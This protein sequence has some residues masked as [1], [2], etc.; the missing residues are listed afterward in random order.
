MVALPRRRIAT[1]NPQLDGRDPRLAWL[2]MN[3]GTI[4][5]RKSAPVAQRIERLPP[6]QEARGSS[7]LGRTMR[8]S[9]VFSVRCRHSSLAVTDSITGAWYAVRTP[10]GVAEWRRTPFGQ[11]LS[12]RPA[13]LSSPRPV[14]AAVAAYPPSSGSGRTGALAVRQGAQEGY[15]WSFAG[16]ARLMPFSARSAR[17][18][19]SLAAKV[20]T[21]RSLD[22]DRPRSRSRDNP[23][24]S[25]YSEFPLVGS[26][27]T[28]I[29]RGLADTPDS[30]LPDSVPP[31]I[32]AIDM[33]T[34]VIAHSTAW[35]GDLESS[36]SLHIHGRVEGSL[37]A[38]ESVF[39]AEEADVDAVIRAANVT[40]AGN[41]RGSVHCAE[42]FE[43]LPRGQSGR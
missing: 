10:P 1:S 2:P 36:G 41:V 43:V 16:T 28:S 27:R 25:E 8:L 9:R 15:A 37:T 39:I 4:A 40:V 14:P 24:L 20:T 13:R 21:E 6:E 18:V 33:H 11:R 30:V 23:Y 3:W 32:P 34:S 26:E 22:R 29:S 31:P 19:T 38:R 17:C 5:R 35:S 7:P 42:R 12:W